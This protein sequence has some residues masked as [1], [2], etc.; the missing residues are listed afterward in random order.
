MPVKVK[1]LDNEYLIKSEE[2][3]IEKVYKIAEYVNQKIK[4]INDN[5]EGLSEK[6]MAILTALNIAGDYFQALK[7]RDDLLGNVRERSEALIHNIDS[8]M[9]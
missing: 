7:E 2:E 5:S 9:S 6:K 8:L 1:I 3:D 4:E